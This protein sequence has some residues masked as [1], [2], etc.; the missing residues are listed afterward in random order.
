MGLTLL[1]GCMTPYAPPGSGGLQSGQV[2]YRSSGFVEFESF[3][4][5]KLVM[6]KAVTREGGECRLVVTLT[7]NDMS[8]P[9]TLVIE[10]DGEEVAL[11]DRQ[12]RTSRRLVGAPRFTTRLS[13]VLEEE[14]VARLRRAQ[15]IVV[16]YGHQRVSLT[17]RERGVLQGLLAG[18]E[19]S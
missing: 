4:S 1:A 12:P 9:D 11:R 18:A 10:A 5:L 2:L 8:A 15:R 17:D 13:F 6:H 16:W 14:L 3:T 19:G 7:Y